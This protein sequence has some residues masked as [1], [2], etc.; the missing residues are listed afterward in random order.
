MNQAL[1]PSSAWLYGLNKEIKISLSKI[2]ETRNH[3]QLRLSR[4]IFNK[5]IESEFYSDAE[6]TTSLLVEQECI[7]MGWERFYYVP[8]AQIRMPIYVLWCYRQYIK[9]A[10]IKASVNVCLFRGWSFS[11]FAS[12]LTK[13]EYAL[14]FGSLEP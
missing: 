11:L 7:K 6:N 13:I 3:V 4:Q 9:A 1:K 8:I 2:R 12:L 14:F 5:F 10:V